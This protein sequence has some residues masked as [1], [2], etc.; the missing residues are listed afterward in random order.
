MSGLFTVSVSGSSPLGLV[1]KMLLDFFSK[2]LQKGS[3]GRIEEGEEEEEEE[4]GGRE[5]EG[6][7]RIEEGEREGG[8]R[9][10]EG[11]GRIE[12]G[13]REGEGGEGGKALKCKGEKQ[14]SSSTHDD[15][16]HSSIQ[17]IIPKKKLEK[18]IISVEVEKSVK[19]LQKKEESLLISCTEKWIIKLLTTT[20][21]LQGSIQGRGGGA[22]ILAGEIKQE[23]L[24][25]LEKNWSIFYKEALLRKGIE[26]RAERKEKREKNSIDMN[27]EKDCVFFAPDRVRKTERKGEIGVTKK[28][29]EEEGKDEETERGGKYYQSSPS[30]ASQKMIKIDLSDFSGLRDFARAAWMECDG[31]EFPAV[32]VQ[33][34]HTPSLTPLSL[35]LDS[36]LPL[37]SSTTTGSVANLTTG[38]VTGSV[39]G[40]TTGMELITLTLTPHLQTA[41]RE[42]GPEPESGSRVGIEI[43]PSMKT[44]ETGKKRTFL[45]ISGKW[46]GKESS[47][48]DYSNTVFTGQKNQN[49]VEVLN[50]SEN[51]RKRKNKLLIV[52]MDESLKLKLEL[53]G[54]RARQG[55]VPLTGTGIDRENINTQSQQME[56]EKQDED[57][58][59]EEE[60]EE[61]EEQDPLSSQGSLWH[62]SDGDSLSRLRAMGAF[63]YAASQG[64]YVR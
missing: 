42:P 15:Y 40:P 18:K 55:R 24:R 45:H 13:E 44:T 10:E 54:R 64:T 52:G 9:E 46:P 60:E 31:G 16:S 56:E 48:M 37:Q 63:A 41:P 22:E 19:T 5:E 34:V 3:A 43:D 58:G 25:F 14:G 53:A 29:E 26:N 49:N 27:E 33:S 35:Q 38:S 6:E 47:R 2:A 4:G 62:H 8:G 11:E 39:T 50:V 23:I 21:L 30:L 57:H 12:E 20:S 32:S 51:E 7:G 61:E 36:L 28:N 59:E 1:V 17:N